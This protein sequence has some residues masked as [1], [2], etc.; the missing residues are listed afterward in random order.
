[1][2]QHS[3]VS[4]KIKLA[5]Q[6]AVENFY[7]GLS[8]SESIYEALLRSELLSQDEAPYFTCAMCAG[9]GGGTGLSGN[10][11]GVLSGAVMA[12]G[13]KHGRKDPRN[14]KPDGLYDVE[15]HRYNLL[16]KDFIEENGGVLCRELCRE[17]IGDW[18]SAARKAA[19]AQIL[20]KTVVIACKYLNISAEEILS[21]PWGY[22][23]TTAS[24][25]P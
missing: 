14:D 22:N 24:E 23:I 18:N 6:Y 3:P 8:C 9:F 16:V 4:N 2:N 19:C 13:A 21:S 12:V 10:N 20:K 11:C 7:G 17:F 15:Y 5:Q 25:A 1:M